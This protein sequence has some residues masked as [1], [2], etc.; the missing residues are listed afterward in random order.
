MSI[1]K[2]DRVQV[3]LYSAVYD[4]HLLK[5][6]GVCIVNTMQLK[7]MH[8]KH[9]LFRSHLKGH[10]PK[11]GYLGKRGAMQTRTL[12]TLPEQSLVMRLA[13]R[14]QVVVCFPVSPCPLS[15]THLPVQRLE[16]LGRGPF[17]V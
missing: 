6:G 17:E 12:V 10:Q 15:H 4:A 3:A 9:M 5:Q 7:G 11:I 1:L 16:G 14:G 8:Y 2:G 13:I